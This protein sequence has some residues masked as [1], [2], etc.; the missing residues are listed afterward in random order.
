MVDPSTGES[1]SATTIRN[2]CHYFREVGVPVCLWTNRGPQFTSHKFQQFTDRWG[3]QH[4]TLPLYQLNGHAEAVITKLLSQHVQIQDLISHR[5]DK[6]RIITGYLQGQELWRGPLKW[7]CVLL[8]PLFSPFSAVPQSWFPPQWIPQCSWKP[9]A[10]YLGR[11]RNKIFAREWTMSMREGGEYFLY[12]QYLW[13]NTFVLLYDIWAVNTTLPNALS[14]AGHLPFEC[15]VL[16][17]T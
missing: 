13:G 7:P 11:L 1:T 17:K 9:H 15:T 4:I 10:R 12:L 16:L 6:V 8:E 14:A 2:F 5:E 3:I